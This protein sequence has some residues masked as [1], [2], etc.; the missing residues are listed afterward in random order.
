MGWDAGSRGRALAA[1]RTLTRAWVSRSLNTNSLLRMLPCYRGYSSNEYWRE[2]GALEE[3]T[4]ARTQGALTQ[5]GG[6]ALDKSAMQHVTL[7]TSHTCLFTYICFSECIIF[8]GLSYFFLLA[9]IC[10]SNSVNSDLHLIVLLIGFSLVSP[11]CFETF[12]LVIHQNPI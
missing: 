11:V 12:P 4:G 7:Y 3:V 5:G 1:Q 6:V 2:R 9:P 10:Q 8:T